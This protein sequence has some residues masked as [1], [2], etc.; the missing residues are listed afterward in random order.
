MILK[1]NHQEYREQDIQ[2]REEAVQ[3]EST[4]KN[5]MMEL[6]HGSPVLF[7]FLYQLSRNNIVVKKRGKKIHHNVHKKHIMK[8]CSQS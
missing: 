3:E 6:T 4:P 7:D 5:M 1:N 2:K 8:M